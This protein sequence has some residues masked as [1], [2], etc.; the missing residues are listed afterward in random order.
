MLGHTTGILAS[1]NKSGLIHIVPIFITESP[2]TFRGI[3]FHTINIGIGNNNGVVGQPIFNVAVGVG[4]N[5]GVVG[6][7]I[8]PVPIGINRTGS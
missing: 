4:N 3:N 6:Q 7:S 1:R 2:N 8:V 5:K